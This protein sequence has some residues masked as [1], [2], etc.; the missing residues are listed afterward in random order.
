MSNLLDYLNNGAMGDNHWE[1][2]RE[3]SNERGT[4]GIY[5]TDDTAL[6]REG[7][8]MALMVGEDMIELDWFSRHLLEAKQ[9]ECNLLAKWAGIEEVQK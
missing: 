3:W 1:I 9:Y 4:L 8:L 5:Q 2:M 7:M 6:G